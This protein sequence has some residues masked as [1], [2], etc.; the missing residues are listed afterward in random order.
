M[1]V[2]YGLLAIGALTT[3]YPFLIMLSTGFK[4]PTDQNDNR[5]VPAFWSDESAL[6]DKYVD[7]K[8][9]ADTATIA[10]TRSGPASAEAVT[11]Y[12]KFLG[13][14]PLDDFTV[15][16]R[17]N[18]TGV[19]GRLNARYQAW[20]RSRFHTIDELNQAY[21]EED[22]S[23]ETVLPPTEAFSRVHWMAQP[24]RKWQEWQLFKASLPSEYRLP[25]TARALYQSFMRTKYR[26]SFDSVPMAERGSAT[27]FGEL[28]PPT[29]GPLLA[30]F[31]RT[32]VPDRYRTQTAE[33]RF[34]DFTGVHWS[35]DPIAAG[36][37]VRLPIEADE[38]Q[39]VHEDQT[40]LKEE[41]ST[42][43]F[44][45]VTRY[46]V[47][48][49]HALL[50]TLIFCGLAIFTTLGVNSLAAYAL[51][52]YPIRATSKIL[53]FLLA[54][55]AFPAE[56]TMIPNFLLLKNLHLLNT[57]AALVLPGAASG[58]MIFMLKG[59]FDS[60]PPELF[61]AAGLDGAPEM[62]MLRKIALP[63]SRPVFGYFALVIFV[64]TYSTFLYAFLVAQDRRMW[65]I[66]VFIYELSGSAPKYVMMAAFTLAALPTMLVFMFAQNVIQRGIVLPSE[67]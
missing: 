16:F 4:G 22:T 66:M 1:A 25:V 58:Y 39:T 11:Q 62:T 64:G 18:P 15:G 14:L 48:N 45:F 7:D 9:A 20:L 34:L 42:R 60:L 19:T 55:M 51:S 29:S 41:F 2:V 37:G 67:R 24:G 10:A 28:S 30:E 35:G 23:F 6:Y 63:L 36:A 21:V 3:L 46:L 32:G 52:R 47:L 44:A 27:G 57:F 17:Q 56:V 59:F 54:T 61:E 13:A 38:R 33:T 50:N 43:N 26:F 12:R 53:I 8:Y 5:L 65:T 49:G 31:E 40:S